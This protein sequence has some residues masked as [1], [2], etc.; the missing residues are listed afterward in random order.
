MLQSKWEL[1]CPASVVATRHHIVQMGAFHF[2][3]PPQHNNIVC[4][5]G[6]CVRK[7]SIHICLEYCSGGALSTC[8]RVVWR[9]HMRTRSP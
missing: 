2:S 7:N 5:L 6:S 3:A 9:A 4:Y 1:H 8:V